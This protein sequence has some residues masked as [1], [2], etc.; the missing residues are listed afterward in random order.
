[1]PSKGNPPP[2]WPETTE[3]DLKIRGRQPQ[4]FNDSVEQLFIRFRKENWD[5]VNKALNPVLLPCRFTDQSAN[6]EDFSS[7]LQVL[8][9]DWAAYGV[10][11]IT[12]GQLPPP[13]KHPE[14]ADRVYELRAAHVPSVDGF[15]NY[16]H[17]ELRCHLNGTFN[18]TNRDA[19]KPPKTLGKEIK[20]DLF[21]RYTIYK[22]PD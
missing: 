17:S 12:V 11:G 21:N 8:Y 15:E 7:A 20:T 3:E 22:E 2:L 4:P 1:M 13:K 10:V 9:P 5:D 14:L 16:A 6:R 18:E 19:N